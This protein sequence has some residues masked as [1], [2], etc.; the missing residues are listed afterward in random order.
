MVVSIPERGRS[1]TQAPSHY[2]TCPSKYITQNK[3]P[4]ETR[5]NISTDLSIIITFLSLKINTE[6]LHPDTQRRLNS[7]KTQ[8]VGQYYSNLEQKLQFKHFYYYDL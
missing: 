6:A 1:K 5:R 8:L 4:R 3:Q 2:E 7:F